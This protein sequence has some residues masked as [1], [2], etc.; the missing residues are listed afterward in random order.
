[1]TRRCSYGRRNVLRLVHALMER[2]EDAVK[3]F[4]EITY[5]EPDNLTAAANLA[6]AL[7]YMDGDDQKNL[8]KIENILKS[9]KKKLIHLR[10]DNFK[11]DSFPDDPKGG[12]ATFFSAM[13]A[14][15][16]MDFMVDFELYR[17]DGMFFLGGLVTIGKRL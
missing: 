10:R 12:L 15:L 7:L 1:M 5:L 9:G 16:N 17:V 13:S 3:L 2:Y 6:E 14:C 4:Y 8:E 11:F